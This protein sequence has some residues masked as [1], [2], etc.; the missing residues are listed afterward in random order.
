VISFGFV[1]CHSRREDRKSRHISPVLIFDEFQIRPF[2]KTA[3]VAPR[4]FQ[5]IRTF[6]NCNEFV[7]QLFAR[8]ADV[9]EKTACFAVLSFQRLESPYGFFKQWPQCTDFVFSKKPDIS[10]R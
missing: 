1:R 7:S 3:A 6:P 2:A 5:D 4:C 8:D 10:G 9:A